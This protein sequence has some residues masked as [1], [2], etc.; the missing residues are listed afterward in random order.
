MNNAAG[1]AAPARSERH[2]PVMSQLMADVIR[3]LAVEVE[4]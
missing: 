4:V 1:G 3:M 2:D